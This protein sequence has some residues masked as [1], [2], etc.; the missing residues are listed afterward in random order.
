MATLTIA[1]L[2]KDFKGTQV[3]KGISLEAASGEFLSLLGPSGCGKTTLL[4]CIAGLETTSS[5]SIHIAGQDVTGLPPEKRHLGMMFQSYALFPHLSVRENVRFGLRM[6]GDQPKARQRELA[7]AALERV[8]MGH[9]GDRMPPQLSGGQQ[10]RVALARAIAVEPR[11]LLLDEP[12][13]NLDARLRED[14]QIELKELHRSLGLTTVFVTHD[15]EEAMSLSDRVVLM[16]GG[17]IEQVG[18]PEEIY[19]APKTAFAADFIGAANLLP[20]TRSGRYAQV[21]ATKDEVLV[22]GEGADGPG[23]VML[24]QEDLELV[25][26]GSAGASLAVEVVAHIYRG[27]DVVYVARVGADEVRIVMP[28]HADLLPSGP[29]A[30]RWHDG[31]A[32]W[33]AD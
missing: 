18:A 11:V 22:V 30:V 25:P 5:G 33:I 13:S 19:S 8:Q 7:Q 10:Q 12:L 31:A 26:A 1:A 14:M 20:A 24:R 2:K 32:R 21:S 28:R 17:V 3:L 4:R 27:A 23:R 6:A 15:Q 9:L 16:N 29:A